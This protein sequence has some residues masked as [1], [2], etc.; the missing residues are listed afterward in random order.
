VLYFREKAA[1]CR[2]LAN[3]ILNQH[4]PAVDAFLA[5]AA[6]FDARAAEAERGPYSYQ[7]E[8]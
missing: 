4:D 7:A 6:E 2:R 3:G 8:A 1:Q 5:M